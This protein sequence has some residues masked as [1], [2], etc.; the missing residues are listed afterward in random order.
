ME[1]HTAPGGIN[2]LRCRASKELDAVVGAW[3]QGFTIE[4][5]EQVLDAFDKAT[6]LF[7]SAIH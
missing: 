2:Q 6:S 1:H 3:I 4:I 7:K 5:A